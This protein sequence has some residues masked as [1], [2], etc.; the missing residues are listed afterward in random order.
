MDTFFSLYFSQPQKKLGMHSYA[1]SLSHGDDVVKMTMIYVVD[2]SHMQK[3]LNSFFLSHFSFPILEKIVFIWN[4]HSVS[5]SIVSLSVR[6]NKIIIQFHLLTLD[7]PK[8][9]FAGSLHLR[10]NHA[11]SISASQLQHNNFF[12]PV[13]FVWFVLDAQPTK[14]AMLCNKKLYFVLPNFYRG[15][16]YKKMLGGDISNRH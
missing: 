4:Q 15:Q 1:L 7:K 12:E 13:I 2:Y 9:H 3:L 5:F 10:F 8:K 11:F 14:P 6:L 16:T